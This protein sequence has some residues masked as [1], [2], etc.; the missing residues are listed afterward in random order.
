MECHRLA[1]D[2]AI[3]D[4]VTL[5]NDC[6]PTVA[7]DH[8]LAHQRVFAPADGVA[9]TAWG[10]YADGEL[11]AFAV[12]KHL[13]EPVP[14][15]EDAATGWVSLLAV[16]P[17]LAD[18]AADG[19]ALLETALDAM[20]GRGVETVRFG[21]DIRKFFPGLPLAAES[22]ASALERV[23]FDRGRRLWDLHCDVASPDAREATTAHLGD[24]A[25]RGVE[26]RRAGPGDEDALRTFVEREFPGRW[27][28][29]V[30]TNCRR[31][32]GLRDYWI[33]ERDGDVVAFARTG[34]AHSTLLSSCVNWIARW[35]ERYCGLGPVGVAEAE[36]GR[37]YGLHLIASAMDAFRREGCHHM[38]VDGVGADLLGYYAQLGFE[39][40]IEFAAY[41]RET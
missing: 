18:P 31:P 1:R 5:W 9:T 19:A 22:Y 37:G 36:R 27:A 4:G 13:R 34:R 2:D 30:A 15:Y 26:A 21:G 41:D 17:L 35:G 7:F 14:G 25:P 6:H 32:G 40:A 38:T 39:P 23:G 11:A 3:R 33:V 24:D 29:Q 20:R 12:T 8:R 28:Y 10:G 16:D